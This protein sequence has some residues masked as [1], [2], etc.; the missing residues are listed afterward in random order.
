MTLDETT[1]N[2][3][4]QMEQGVEAPIP[5]TIPSVVEPQVVDE[6]NDVDP[7]TG[8]PFSIPRKIKLIKR[9]ATFS[10]EDVIKHSHTSESDIQHPNL[11]FDVIQNV[12]KKGQLYFS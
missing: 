3:R 2:K 5:D 6:I 7:D 10:S 9:M 11:R 12:L 8:Q 4:M 1:E